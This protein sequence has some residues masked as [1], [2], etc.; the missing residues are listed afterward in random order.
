MVLL[1]AATLIPA[2]CCQSSPEFVA[3][4]PSSLTPS[5]ESVI[6]LPLPPASTTGFPSPM[7]IPRRVRRL[8]TFT[9]S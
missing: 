2:S 6:A 8:F 3:L 7:S 1:L 4:N 9:F 5:E